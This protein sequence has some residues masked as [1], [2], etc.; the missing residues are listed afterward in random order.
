MR[1]PFI[2]LAPTQHFQDLEKSGCSRDPK[3]NEACGKLK[4]L[5]TNISALCLLQDPLEAYLRIRGANY[6]STAP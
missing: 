6:P 1:L 3:V 2:L 4:N 5:A